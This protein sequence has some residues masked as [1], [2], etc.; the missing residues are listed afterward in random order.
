MLAHGWRAPAWLAEKQGV[1]SERG[2]GRAQ[3]AL[4]VFVALAGKNSRA[5]EG[6][7]CVAALSSVRE[8]DLDGPRGS[9]DCL[10]RR[11]RACHW[12]SG[13]RRDELRPQ[14][15]RRTFLGRH[16][17]RCGS[18]KPRLEL[19]HGHEGFVAAS[20]ESQLRPDVVFDEV[21]RDPQCFGDVGL[22][23]GEAG[24]ARGAR[25]LLAVVFCMADER[26]LTV[27]ASESGRRGGR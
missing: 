8:D 9:G 26:R 22:G 3:N 10:I 6:V 19:P 21:D 15:F 16:R 13:T 23:E 12:W 24:D 11:E 5:R 2:F 18:L 20:D 17:P 1:L 4:C 25:R 27:S 14:A 7:V